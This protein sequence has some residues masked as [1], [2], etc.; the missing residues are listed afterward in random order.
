ML[1]L[2]LQAAAACSSK[3]M[4][5]SVSREE[6]F[7]AAHRLHVAE[8]SDEKNREF[9][10]LCNRPNF[11][12][13][14]YRVIVTVSG[15]VDPISGYVLDM[16][17]LKDILKQEVTEKFDHRNLNLDTEEFKN[18]NPTAENIAVVI[19]N[20][21]KAKLDPSLTLSITLYETD[22]NFVQYSGA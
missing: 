22:R 20:K 18:L 16:K 7:N 2:I 13:H 19:W 15:E 5:V 12:G 6:T 8:W 9:F 17:T 14:N 11:H 3:R 4:V 21:L 10:G 1:Y